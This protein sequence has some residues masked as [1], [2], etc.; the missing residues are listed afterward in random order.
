[1]TPTTLNTKP[2]RR[3]QIAL[4]EPCREYGDRPSYTAIVHV[5]G[6]GVAQA[7]GYDANETLWRA[8][9]NYRARRA[10]ARAAIA[11]HRARE[12]RSACPDCGAKAR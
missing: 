10:G 2:V 6:R 4:I 5:N 1:M 9:N 3:F 8:V 12:E 7:H 11:R